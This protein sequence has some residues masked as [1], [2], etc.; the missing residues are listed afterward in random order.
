M[1]CLDTG[2]SIGEKIPPLLL[3]ICSFS[4]YIISKLDQGF[5][6]LRSILLRCSLC[7]G[8]TVIRRIAGAKKCET[9]N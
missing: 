3:I 6:V 5:I 2:I 9:I 7:C 4:T 8:E 1:P